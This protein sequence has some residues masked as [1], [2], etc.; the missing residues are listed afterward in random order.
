VNGR[1]VVI[2]KKNDHDTVH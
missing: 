1:F 2:K